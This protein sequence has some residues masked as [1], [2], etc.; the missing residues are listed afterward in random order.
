[1]GSLSTNELKQLKLVLA[2]VVTTISFILDL[3]TLTTG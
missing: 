3:R 2:F 1:M